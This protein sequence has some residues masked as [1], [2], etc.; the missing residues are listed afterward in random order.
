MNSN[1]STVLLVSHD[2]G[3][4]QLVASYAKLELNLSVKILAEGPAV[5]VFKEFFPDEFFIDRESAFEMLGCG[6][7]SCVITSTS[8]ESRLELESI[9]RAKKTGV[10]VVC[11][12]DHWVNYRERF[13]WPD[14]NWMEN[15]PDELWAHD[16]RSLEILQKI[17]PGVTVTNKGNKF[18]EFKIQNLASGSIAQKNSFL[19]LTEPIQKHQGNS[20]GYDEFDAI[21]LFIGKIEEITRGES[22]KITLRPHP[23][24]RSYYETKYERYLGPSF[25]YS[26][27]TD[28]FEDIEAHEYVV[29]CETIALYYAS[30]FNKKLLCS[31]PTNDLVSLPITDIIYLR[32]I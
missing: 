13:L 32:D 22:F 27:N 28:V 16:M 7:F 1:N 29:G 19:L 31:I 17:F 6:I 2:V 14:L 5:S 18:V 21:E 10:K 23:S 25:T 3:G 26:T 20:L 11:Y 9:K 4:A 8:W 12:I 15:L 24:E 30:L